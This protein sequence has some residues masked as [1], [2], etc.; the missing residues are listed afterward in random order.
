MSNST[1]DEWLLALLDEKSPEE[2][3]PTEMTLLRERATSSPALRRGLAN[4][5]KLEEALHAVLG[6][7][8]VTSEQIIR[9]V[10]AT[11]RK[12]VG[13][14]IAAMLLLTAATGFWRLASLSVERPDRAAPIARP[15][16]Q[17]QPAASPNVADGEASPQR[18]EVVPIEASRPIVANQQDDQAVARSDVA[19][20][21]ADRRPWDD[22]LGDEAHVLPFAQSAFAR[23]G[24]TAPG[25]EVADEYPSSALNR[26][27]AAVP[28]RPFNVNEGQWRGKRFAGLEGIARL[29]PTWRDDA[30]L[31]I[32]PFD[33]AEFA[34]HFWSGDSGT[35]IRFYPHQRPQLLAAYSITR[36]GQEPTPK[37]LRLVATDGGTYSRANAGAMEIRH[38]EGQL[39]VTRG[40]LPL[41]V[42]PMP[43]SPSEVFIETRARLRTLAMYR[44]EAAP[45]PPPTVHKNLLADLLPDVPSWLVSTD[46][47]AKVE[48]A[49][50]QLTLTATP[51]TPGPRRLSWAALP[52]PEATK[53][54]LCEAVFR[55]ESLTPG[56]GLYLGNADG[57]PIHTLFASENNPAGAPVLAYGWTSRDGNVPE[58]RWRWDGDPKNELVSAAGAG[59]WVKLIVGSGGLKVYFSGDGEHWGPAAR[60]PERAVRGGYASVGLFTIA[61]DKPRS[62]TI[63]DVDV[64][65]LSGVISVADPKLRERVPAFDDKVLER[66]ADW[67]TWA[68]AS[69]P[70]EY[71]VGRWLTACG[72]ETL[73]RG[74]NDAVSS[75]IISGL[76]RDSVDS[77]RPVEQT[78]AL[79][80][81]LALLSDLWNDRAREFA[82]AYE[83]LSRSIAARAGEPSEI[84]AMLASVEEAYLASPMW[85]E[86]RTW[87][88]P[89]AT[90]RELAASV[91]WSHDKRGAASAKRLA[92]YLTPAH[93]EGGWSGEE[94]AGLARLVAWTD[95]FASG[96]GSRLEGAARYGWQH[97]LATEPGREGTTIAAE[98]HAALNV[99]AYEDAARLLATLAELSDL[100]P[101]IGDPARFVPPAG[102]IAEAA[103]RHPE[104]VTTLEERFGPAALLRVR[105]AIAAGDEA[106]VRLA[107]VRYYGT[108]AASEARRWLG[109][110]ALAAGRFAEAEDHFA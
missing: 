107:A 66:P 32:A 4:R 48:Y 58:P 106:A 19:E 26:W 88:I 40:A 85:T 28:G 98:L 97:P 33:V 30:V 100:V 11:R 51:Q 110:T 38:Q 57:V 42:V 12:R 109:E 47:P 82:D 105:Q 64:S 83:R 72:V 70:A 35:A 87:A 71:E 31:R 37:T 90:A 41:L 2:L 95:A 5:L 80:H 29:L 60:N 77:D 3:T 68:T 104:L 75:S 74:A 27:I 59:T 14:W 9:R 73:A 102:L 79:L 78:L 22:V 39:V 94:D 99:G 6:E 91:I 23:F 20:P 76:I 65:E 24:E 10:N 45:L 1:S 7:P 13:A 93:P 86:S 18:T 92:A 49:D 67:L 15:E 61:D 89:P 56:S 103:K 69:R 44:G 96:D 55:I 21:D 50:G 36:E 63:T 108:A 46:P 52:L 43:E 53:T 62:I 101:A 16:R 54:G 17:S 25:F 34:L 8:S 84:A 81:D